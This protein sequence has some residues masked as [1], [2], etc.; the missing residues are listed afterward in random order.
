MRPPI[1]CVRCARTKAALQSPFHYSRAPHSPSLEAV[2]MNS[3]RS[4]RAKINGERHRVSISRVCSSFFFTIDLKLGAISSSNLYVHSLCS[5][6]LRVARSARAGRLS[7]QTRYTNPNKLLSKVS[8]YVTIFSAPLSFGGRQ[9]QRRLRQARVWWKT[10]RMCD[11]AVC[12][13][14]IR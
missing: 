9:C 14:E 1:T 5:F 2:M 10:M 8:E 12:A 13:W 11:A 4:E 7:F 6:S 3:R